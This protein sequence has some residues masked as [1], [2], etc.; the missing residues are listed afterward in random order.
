MANI[1]RQAV[2]GLALALALAA[3]AE[4]RAQNAS[5]PSPS[6]DPVY[7]SQ[8]AAFDALQEADRKAIQD[9][10]VWNGHY[11]GVVDGVFGKRTRDA[12]VAYQ[13]SVKA[14]TSGIV[15]AAQLAAMTSAAQKARTTLRFQ[16]FTDDKTGVKIG[17]P[18]KILDKRVANDSGG[19]RLMKADG[20]IVLDLSSIS[21]SDAKMGML[22]AALIADAPGRKITLK[23]SRPD[24][25]VVSGEE[26]GRKFYERMAK[27]PANW[28][29][30]SAVRGF[31]LVYPAAQSADFDRVGVAIADSFEPF[32]T[33]ASSSASASA[34]S[35]TPVPTPAP[36]PSRPVFAATGLLVAPGQA[37][38]VI[39]AADCPN[40]TIDGKPAKFTRDDRD[41]GLSILSADL[42]SSQT[43][44][45]PNFGTLGPDL[46]ALSYAAE[47]PGG[48]V[49][50]NVT[51]ASPLAVNKNDPSN[52][53]ASLSKNARGAPVFDRKGG[54]VAII[55]QSAGE[56]RLVAGVAPTA[57]HGMIGADQ[58]ERFLSL[59][60]DSTTRPTGDAP[61]GAGQ[62]AAAE[63][64]NVV[65]ISCRR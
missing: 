18:M 37:L 65:A 64:G 19:V 45:A 39:G 57:V 30:S 17:A 41:A 46:V 58:I 26:S 8:K 53:L 11:L 6:V 42:S 51:S 62:I 5:P 13:T 7:D 52:L 35:T 15:D 31:R 43:V 29:D 25:F 20:S 40:P 54:L 36:A 1:V 60:P 23:V 56:P 49:V 44:N 59:T 16:I 33:A 22:F 48:R 63:R 4:L 27:A 47:E 3:P 2:C 55:A 12:I 24:F 21:G 61:L 34:A 50:L 32:P 9:S 28:P 38:S 10:L 14:P